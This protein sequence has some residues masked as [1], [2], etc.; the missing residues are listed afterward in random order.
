[1]NPDLVFE[2]AGLALACELGY[3]A[4]HPVYSVVDWRQAVNNGDTRY[5]YWAW[6]AAMA[7]DT[8]AETQ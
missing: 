5:G 2:K 4:V 6:V 1:M 8:E 7:D 3:W